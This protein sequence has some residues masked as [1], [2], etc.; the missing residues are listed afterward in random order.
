MP[1]ILVSAMTEDRVIGSG[2]G[3]PWDI[4]AEYRHY[5]EMIRGHTV[6]MGRKSLEIFGDDLTCA[7]TIVV[8]RSERIE[9]ENVEFA[10]SVEEA[11]RMAAR[12]P[13]DTYVAGGASIYEQAL[14]SANRMH[15]STIHGEYE[16][17]TYFPAYDPGDWLVVRRERR[18]GYDYTEYARAREG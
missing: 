3:M 13:G 18:E 1:I 10:S 6:V 7:R 14:S 16:G 15:L 12:G 8:T 9:G 2:D 11:L 17:D 4:P 5:L